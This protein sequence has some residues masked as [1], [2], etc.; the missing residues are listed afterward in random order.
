[1]KNTRLVKC[2]SRLSAGQP[3]PCPASRKPLNGV[4]KIYARRVTRQMTV[5]L[6]FAT[7][8]EFKHFLTAFLKLKIRLLNKS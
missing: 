2:S 1:M 5:T 7:S 6:K 4:Q 8:L 3:T